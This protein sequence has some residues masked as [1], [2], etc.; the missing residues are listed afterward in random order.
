MLEAIKQNS[1]DSKYYFAGTS[2][3]FGG[4]NCP[5]TGYTES[6]PF[7]PRSPYAV[8]K[9]ASFSSVRNYREAYNIFGCNGILFNHS[10]L[11]R[12]EDFATRKI[13]VGVAKVKLGLVDHV[14]MGNL[15]ACRDEGSS[16]DYVK[17]MHL[18]LQQSKPDDY[19][20]ATGI[21]PSIRD[22][23]EY[24]CTLAG[25]DINNVYKQE[26]R[27]MRPSDVPI[28]LGNASKIKLL[29]WKPTCTWQALLES[30]YKNDLYLLS[31]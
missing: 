24:V 22:Q 4:L 23:L 1:P 11:R 9:Q 19:V 12:G 20:V 29:G 5:I 7:H 13:S 15:D 30:M 3:L 17:A 26:D 16:I 25:L 6:S 28:L 14:Y 2:E 27:F 18:M 8:A 21:A 31:K 10:S